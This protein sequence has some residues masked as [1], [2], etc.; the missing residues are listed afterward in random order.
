VFRRLVSLLIVPLS[1]L[2]G[3]EA[4]EWPIHSLERPRPAVVHPGGPSTTPP[5][6][7]A[8]VLFDGGPLDNWRSNRDS[9]GRALWT[10]N[11]GVLAVEPGSGGIHTVATFGDIQLHVEW[12]TPED[13]VSLGQ[14]RG[15]S[16][17]FLM[18]YYEVQVLDSWENITYADGQ[19]AA[20][21]GQFPPSVNVSLPPDSWQSYDILFR[22]PWFDEEG[23]VTS[24]ATMTVIHNGVLVHESV[25]L[26]GPT[27]HRTREP[28]SAHPDRLPLSL[29]DHGTGVRF[30][31]IWARPL[32]PRDKN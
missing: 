13:S 27:S 19:A 6:A 32:P 28:Y 14:D 8:V 26:L 20:I 17:V 11:R 10:V 31:N 23:A 22:R 12:M 21:Y 3:Q 7:D 16:G 18:G 2:A 15:N 24:P 29:Q 9:T 30:R 5:P 25:E 1:L 4:E